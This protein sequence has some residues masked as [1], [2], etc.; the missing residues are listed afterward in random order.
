MPRGG[1]KGTRFLKTAPMDAKRGRY[2]LWRSM[3]VLTRAQGGFGRAALCTV[4]G[5]SMRNVEDYLRWLMRAGYVNKVSTTGRHHVGF[6]VLVRD[7]G[8]HAPR[9]RADGTIF[10]LN[11]E[12]V[13]DGDVSSVD[14]RGSK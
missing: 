9:V 5:T 6:Y 1:K 3:R 2:K 8:P 11:L 12:R 4:T 14:G 13:N 7:T 10:D